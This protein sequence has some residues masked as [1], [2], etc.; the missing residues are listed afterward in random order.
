MANNYT[1]KY[2]D[3]LSQIAKTFGT[4]V[5]A[6]A[7]ANGIAN[8]NLI[9]AGSTIVIPTIAEVVDTAKATIDKTEKATT[10][11]PFEYADYEESDTVKALGDKKSQAEDAVTNYGDFDFSKQADYDSIYDQYKNRKDFSYDFNA[12]ALYQQYKD[13]YIQQGKM[14]M[15]DAMGQAS[16]MTGGY[17]NSYAASVGNQAYQSHLQNLNDI[18]PEL[19]QMAYEKYKQEGQDMLNMM[20]L[21]GDE[22]NFEYGVWGDG[23]N[24]LVADRDYIAGQY[25]S[26][27]NRDYGMYESD[28]NLAQTEHTNTESFEYQNHR[29]KI[30]DEQW[31]KDF[32]YRSEQDKIANERAER[33]LAM[34]EEAWELEKC[35]R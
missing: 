28:R 17:G 6:L 13:K 14:A 15:A 21:L 8:P 19:Y 26:E 27:W 29:D 3:T 33:E 30:A 35:L 10:Y 1:I 12:D 25:D 2:G 23:Y 34:A 32:D 16:A 22:R 7:S 24:R 20:A 9:K 5:S 11:D 18:I 4:T 31:Q